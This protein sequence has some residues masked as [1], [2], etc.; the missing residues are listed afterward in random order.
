MNTPHYEKTLNDLV[1][2]ARMGGFRVDNHWQGVKHGHL[3]EFQRGFGTRLP[4]Q[5]FLR[6]PRVPSTCVTR[7]TLAK[8]ARSK[9]ERRKIYALQNLGEELTTWVVVPP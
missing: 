3:V 2:R 7:H 4:S 5:S 6:R 8:G 9:H 1:Q